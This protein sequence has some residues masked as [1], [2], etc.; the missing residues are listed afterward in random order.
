MNINPITDKAKI[1]SVLCDE[2]VY[3]RISEDGAATIDEYDPP[4]SALYLTDD[5]LSGLM[6][7]HPINA[8][9]Y[10]THIQMIDKTKA[11]EFGQS[12]LKWF[13]KHSEAIKIVAQIPEIYPDVCRFAEKNGFEKEGINRASYLKNGGVFN[14]IYYGLSR[15]G[16]Q[17]GLG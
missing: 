10:E 12:C 6:I 1:R 11:M 2:W 3:S 4:M 9:S 5:N 13:W 8:A 14:Q 15:P 16:G 7:F 17:Y